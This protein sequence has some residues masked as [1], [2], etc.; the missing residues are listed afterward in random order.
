MQPKVLVWYLITHY[1]HSFPMG[2]YEAISYKHKTINL[3]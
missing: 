1:K 3:F 2:A